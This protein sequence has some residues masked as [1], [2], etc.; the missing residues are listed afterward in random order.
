MVLTIINYFLPIF[1]FLLVF[2]ICYSFLQKTKILGEKPG[3]NILISLILSSFFI[4]ES[5]LVVFIEYTSTWITVLVVV[6]FFLF[7]VI[8]I[9][10]DKDPLKIFKNGWFSWLLL[11]II[12]LI[13]ISSAIYI[14]NLTVTASGTFG[15]MN[16]E[17]FQFF[18]LVII[19]IIVSTILTK[20]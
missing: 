11:G 1:A 18:L 19:S 14:F 7:L 17:I 8:S 13:F 16:S 20:K 5:Q 3:L 15:W 6:V 10:P 9:I 12:I 2:I 4:V